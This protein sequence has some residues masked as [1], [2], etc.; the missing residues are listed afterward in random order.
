MS[1]VVL[2]LSLCE[3]G[4]CM[5]RVLDFGV[6]RGGVTHVNCDGLQMNEPSHAVCWNNWLPSPTHSQ[7]GMC[8]AFVLAQ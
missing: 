3:L 1:A 8:V 6:R 2:P 4:R 5:W 7:C